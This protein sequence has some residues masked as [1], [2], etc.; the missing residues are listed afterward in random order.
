MAKAMD[1]IL[2]KKQEELQKENTAQATV[3]SMGG[4]IQKNTEPRK[5]LDIGNF[6]YG[7]FSFDA[8]RESDAVKAAKAA[9]DAQL[10]GKPKS[11]ESQWMTQLDDVLNQILNREEFSYD[12]NGDAFY[13]MYKNLYQGQGKKAMQDAMGQAS[14]M[15]GGYGNSY[16][17]TVGNQAYGTYLEKMNEV[18]PTLYQ[19]AYDMYRDEGDELSKRYALLGDREAQDYAKYRDMVSDWQI[20]RDRLQSLYDSERDFDYGKYAD[21]R[22]FA[23]GTYADE[24]DY[25]YNEYRDQIADEM[26]QAEFDEMKRQYEEQMASS[27]SP[28]LANV[29]SMT[30]AQLVETMSNYKVNGDLT[31]LR[32]FLADCVDSGRLSLEAAE[33]YYN[34]YAGEELPDTSSAL[35]TTV[36]R[37]SGITKPSAVNNVTESDRK[38]KAAMIS[39]G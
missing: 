14:A 12:V 26:W 34:S 11:Y 24:R 31:G 16:A 35:D 28:G 3:P 1:E 32:N 7:D 6:T 9:L 27:S 19:M 2:K 23:Y 25:A 18:V 36:D 10:A 17:S 33:A 30:S 15:T 37:L 5:D 13:Q 8:Y 4:E 21:E 22:D 39:F 38:K 20:E 29:G